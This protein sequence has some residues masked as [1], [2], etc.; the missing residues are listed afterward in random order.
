MTSLRLLPSSLACSALLVASPLA[1]PQDCN[2][3]GQD[4]ATD[5]VT[6]ASLDCNG[7]GVPDECDSC[8][9]TIVLIDFEGFAEG[10]PLGDQYT[11]QGVTFALVGDPP[12][13]PVICTEGS[14]AL[15][16]GGPGGDDIPLAGL[17][18]LT[19]PLGSDGSVATDARD[20]EILFDPPVS[21]LSLFVVDLDQTD[22]VELSAFAGAVLV[23]S[24]FQAAGSAG[25][26]DGIG[27]FLTVIGDGITRA[28]V[29]VAPG[30]GYA[31]DDLSFRRGSGAACGTLFRIAQESAPGAGDFDANVVGTVEA[32]ITAADVTSLYSYDFP[33]AS[34]Y[35]GSLLP[36]VADRSLLALVETAQGLSLF[37]FHD[38]AVPD[39]SDGGHAEM[40][41]ELSGDLDGAEITAQDDPEPSTDGDTYTGSAGASLF[42]THN[43]WSPCCTDGVVISGLSDDWSMLVQFT[44]TNA[45]ATPPPIQGLV[46]WV[47]A[48]GDGG[49]IALALEEDRRVRIDRFQGPCPLSF[50]PDVLGLSVA[51]GGTQTLSLDAG[52]EHAGAIYFVLGSLSGT[53]PGTDLGGPILLPLNNDFYFA[54]TLT[55]P[56]TAF[57][58]NAIGFLDGAGQG[59]AMATLAPGLSPSLVGIL[60]HHAFTLL[61]QPFVSNPVPVAL[62]P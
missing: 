11:A 36:A 61:N 56:N 60:A 18:G 15:G 32:F 46:D 40:R 26:G 37:S 49:A 30:M 55:A 42:T 8:A 59:T 16:F 24:E 9:E 17:G 34:S 19:D 62:V 22:T 48:S 53:Q 5:L 51:A 23:G 14:P 41:F 47:F 10:T 58:F 21:D 50:L 7:N 20:V 35:N 39:D 52:P 12:G 27:T 1:G 6:G 54:L 3:N 31:I 33:E 29:D 44:D 13:L 38:R 45:T 2:R 25:T 57:L 4:D 28:V 43:S